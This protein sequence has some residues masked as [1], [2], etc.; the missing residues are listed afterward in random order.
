[1][2]TFARALNPALAIGLGLMSPA[3]GLGYAAL[4]PFGMDALGDMT[5]SRKDEKHKDAMEDA[6]GFFRGPGSVEGPWSNGPSRR[7]R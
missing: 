4:S 1:M 6:H 3:L 2:G 5:N 7:L